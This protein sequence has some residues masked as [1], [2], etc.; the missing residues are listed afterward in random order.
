MGETEQERLDRASKRELKRSEY[1][2]DGAE[3]NNDDE[4]GKVQTDNTKENNEF[5]IYRDDGKERN[6]FGIEESSL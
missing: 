6:P 5:C 1:C 3:R 4:E 2:R